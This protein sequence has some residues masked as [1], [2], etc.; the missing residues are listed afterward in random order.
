AK[1]LLSALRHSVSDTKNVNGA[2]ARMRL[3]ALS[4]QLAA[5]EKALSLVSSAAPW[6]VE[7]KA[8]SMEFDRLKISATDALNQMNE[9]VSYKGLRK[10]TMD[11]GQKVRFIAEYGQEKYSNL[12]N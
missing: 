9:T 10:S 8:M 1:S 5:T 11:V 7:I 4:S 12:P 2:N 6:N 3:E